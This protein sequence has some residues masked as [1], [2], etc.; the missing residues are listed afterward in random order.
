ME[1]LILTVFLSL[2]LAALFLMLFLR[3]QASRDRKGPEQE[4]LL[5]FREER[6]APSARRNR[7]EAT[8]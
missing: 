2:L 8:L 5:P 3:N 4:S 6:P 7:H 1:I